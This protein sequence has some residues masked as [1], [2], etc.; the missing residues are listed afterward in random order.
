MQNRNTDLNKQAIWVAAF[1]GLALQVTPL[2]ARAEDQPVVAADA[3]SAGLDLG[4]SLTQFAQSAVQGDGDNAWETGGK[5]DAV[6]SL[7]GAKLGLWQGLTVTI[8]QEWVYG[9]DVNDQGDGSL[10][11]V[12]VALGFPRLGGR[13]AETS[14]VLTQLINENTSV[15]VGK[16]NMLDAAARTPLM[17]GGGV[18]TFSHVGLAAPISGV[19]P[20]YMLGVMAT[21][22]SDSLI[23]TLM[24]YDP[25]NAQDTEVL[26]EP[27]SDGAT[28][29]LSTT[30]PV[31]FRGLKGFQGVRAVYSTQSGLDLQSIPQLA[32]PPAAE[33]V[34][35]EKSPYW[36]LAYSFQQYLFMQEGDAT[37]GWGVF[38]QLAVSDGNPNTVESSLFVGLGGDS[39]WASRRNDAWGIGYFR[40]NLSNSLLEGLQAIGVTNLRDEMG[41]EAFYRLA[42]VDKMSLTANLVYIVPGEANRQDALFAGF[43]AQVRY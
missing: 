37:R 6:L 2:Q 25:R 22:R 30:R 41:A 19:T 43:R 26:R 21:H 38:G 13:D 3:D 18:N 40:Y 12:N 34:V 4:L 16:F 1:L 23:T 36:Y 11:P 33:G 10:L 42:I 15:S 9:N 17:G 29:S 27:F 39:P 28:I 35:G 5:V 24:V 32:L 7:Q 14:V 20:P 31:S 8:H